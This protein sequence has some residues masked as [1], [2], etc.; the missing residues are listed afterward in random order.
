MS[1]HEPRAESI[2]AEAKSMDFKVSWANRKSGLF[3]TI[4]NDGDKTMDDMRRFARTFYPSCIM[5]SG[6]W[7]EATFKVKGSPARS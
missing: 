5:T 7:G 4:K 6:G 1:K 2:K 3:M